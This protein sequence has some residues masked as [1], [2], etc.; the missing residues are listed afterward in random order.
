MKIVASG[1][2]AAEEV[3]HQSGNRVGRPM[4]AYFPAL[5]ESFSDTARLNTGFSAV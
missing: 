1:L 4:T 2:K 3:L 5:H